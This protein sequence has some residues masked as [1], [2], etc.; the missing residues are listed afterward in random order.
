MRMKKVFV[1]LILTA[2]AL[3]TIFSDQKKGVKDTV[4]S[5]YQDIQIDFE[6]QWAFIIAINEYNHLSRLRYPVKEAQQIEVLLKNK[7]GYFPKKIKTL[8][9]KK[10]TYSAIMNQL[11]WYVKYL[12]DKDN[13]FIYFS[14]HGYKDDVLKKGFWMPC[15]AGSD[16]QR[17]KNEKDKATET[18]VKISNHDI[19]DVLRECK[20]RHIFV[21]ADSCFSGQFFASQHNVAEVP[22]THYKLKS[23]QLL[24]SG[25]ELVGDGD[26]GKYFVRCLE[27]NEE[28][29]L[30][31]SDLISNV[32]TTVINN[33]DLEPE[34][35]PVR[36]TGDEGGE[37]ILVRRL[38]SLKQLEYKPN[39]PTDP[40]DIDVTGI[41]AEAE[42]N[43]LQRERKKQI[44]RIGKG[45]FKKKSKINKKSKMVKPSPLPQKENP[46]KA[47]HT[48]IKRIILIPV[49]MKN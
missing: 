2:L 35:K 25:R 16:K 17:I 28:P 19:V 15:D 44:G 49:K 46:G 30:L 41:K 11:K 26:F 1:F 20:A 21:V 22:V 24:A 42:R 5:Y 8:L 33:T 13:L 9:D 3:S 29:Y 43:R 6:N 27:S 7:Y 34:G 23:R 12:K 31:A 45:T 39:L 48:N 32:R 47:F 10:A 18:L 14:G 36:N 40:T 4:T 38:A 37:F